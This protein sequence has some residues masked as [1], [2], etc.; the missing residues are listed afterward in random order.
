[1]ASVFIENELKIDAFDSI[2]GHLHQTISQC[3]TSSRIPK[4]NQRTFYLLIY[5]PL[6]SILTKFS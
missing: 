4:E 3:S 1:M 5:V 2:K 6:S